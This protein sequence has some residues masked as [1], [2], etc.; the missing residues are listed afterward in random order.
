MKRLKRNPEKYSPLEVYS[1]FSR[2]GGYKLR[3]QEDIDA[4]MINFGKQL[5]YSQN[6]DILIHGKRVEALFGNIAAGLGGCKF[7]KSEDAG[8]AFSSEDIQPPDYKL[9]LNDGTHIFIEV[10]N[11]NQSRPQSSVL[12][13]KKNIDKIEAYGGLHGIAV[14]YAIYY[15]CVNR[16]VM[17]PKSSFIQ[18]KRKYATN[19][20]HS[21]ANNAM[22]MIGDLMIG[23]KPDLVF[24]L[25][26]DK[27]K[28]SSIDEK[29]KANFIIGD[30][31]IHCNANEIDDQYEKKLAFYFMRFGD[32][33]CGDAEATLDDDGSLYSV[34]YIF[35]PDNHKNA[36]LNGFDFIGNLSSMITNAFNEVTV[37]D[38]QVTSIDTRLEPRDFSITIA[39]DYKGKK[40]PLWFLNQQPNTEFNT[41]DHTGE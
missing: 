7:I 8:E 18:L 11:C 41:L 5:N 32:W 13:D 6:D 36:E 34:K 4:F 37:S 20:I 24:E 35:K 12:L 19:L 2:D 23:T 16:W 31:K 33:D 28:E 21:M 17:L 39:D 1:Q 9:I 30:I 29:N 10:K 14:Y 22:G 3:V 27:S 25:L 26:V 38:R 40:L 15:R